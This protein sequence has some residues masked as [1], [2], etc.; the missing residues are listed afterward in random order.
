MAERLGRRDSVDKDRVSLTAAEPPEP[1][2]RTF[3]WKGVLKFSLDHPDQWTTIKDVSKGSYL[4]F[5][6]TAKNY[7][8]AENNGFDVRWQVTEEGEGKAER[9]IVWVKPL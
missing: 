8:G 2:S 7:N 1:T 5:R 4:N 9:G 3:T 6:S